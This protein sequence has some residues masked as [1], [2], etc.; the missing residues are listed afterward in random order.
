M[1]ASEISHIEY[2]AEVL[3]SAKPDEKWAYVREWIGNV[4]IE[5][6][7]TRGAGN[8]YTIIDLDAD[9][10]FVTTDYSDAANW[11]LQVVQ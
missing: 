11:S 10:I 6:R 2:D 7:V 8:A 1:V 3:L 9:T 4:F 5:V